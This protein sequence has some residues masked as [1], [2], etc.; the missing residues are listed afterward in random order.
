MARG[1][2]CGSFNHSGSSTLIYIESDA[3][4]F[5]VTNS[6]DKPLLQTRSFDEAMSKARILAYRYRDWIAL[7]DSPLLK[8]PGGVTLFGP[9]ATPRRIAPKVTRSGR[10]VV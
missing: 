4:R 6:S 9:Q 8:V 1:C 2:A 3:Q 10:V 7:M 5:I